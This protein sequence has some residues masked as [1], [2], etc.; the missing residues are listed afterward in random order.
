MKG[1]EMK[2]TSSKTRESDKGD[3][4]EAAIKKLMQAE[5]QKKKGIETISRR[6][7]NA[8]L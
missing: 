5:D 8:Y 7:T 2:K 6:K 1:K 4:D 3:K